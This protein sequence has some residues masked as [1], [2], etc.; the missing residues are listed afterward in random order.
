MSV[1]GAE[2]RGRCPS[3]GCVAATT[4]NAPASL[5]NIG[6]P[7]QR[8]S[9]CEDGAGCSS[10]DRAYGDTVDNESGPLEAMIATGHGAVH[11]RLA[12]TAG[13]DAPGAVPLRPLRASRD[14]RA[15]IV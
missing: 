8:V 4:S 6:P 14:L 7:E 10:Y 2:G 11:E 9:V 5:Q 13:I 1:M 15:T 3:A 12:V